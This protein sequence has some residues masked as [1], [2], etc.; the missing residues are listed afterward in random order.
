M[1]LL[2]LVVISMV[3]AMLLVEV[4]GVRWRVDGVVGRVS[5]GGVA[6]GL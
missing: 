3:L 1:W 2:V 6:M 4:D 5:M